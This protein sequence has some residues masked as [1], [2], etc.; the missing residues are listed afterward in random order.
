MQKYCALKIELCN[1]EK[2]VFHN[3][4]EEQVKEVKEKI[5]VQGVVRPIPGD[6]Y[7]KELINPFIIKSAFIIDQ[8]GFI[9]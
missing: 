9:G 4:N 2:I 3:L 1:G 7:A 5:W 6:R 8:D